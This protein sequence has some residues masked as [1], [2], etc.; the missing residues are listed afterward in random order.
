[1][2]LWLIQRIDKDSVSYDE[3]DA[4]VI[5]AETEQEVRHIAS[6]KHGDEG[7]HVWEDSA[8]TSVTELLVEG[9]AE[10]IL[11]SFNAG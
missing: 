7:G 3:Y 6:G 5:R 11:A 8:I 4:F 2:K 1:M 9:E 10:V